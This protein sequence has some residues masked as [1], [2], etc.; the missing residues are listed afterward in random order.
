[1]LKSRRGV[2]GH[3]VEAELELEFFEEEFGWSK[4]FEENPETV[5][6]VGSEEAARGIT[7]RTEPSLG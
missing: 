4:F 1:V 5:G 3:R 2:F 7:V 6:I